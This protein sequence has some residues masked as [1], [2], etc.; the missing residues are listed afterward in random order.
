[1]GNAQCSS[2]SLPGKLAGWLGQPGRLLGMVVLAGLLALSFSM[3]SSEPVAAS[4]GLDMQCRVSG[5]FSGYYNTTNALDDAMEG[6][7]FEDQGREGFGHENFYVLDPADASFLREDAVVVRDSDGWKYSTYR[8]GDDGDIAGLGSFYTS[9]PE[10]VDLVYF[11]EF[12][13]RAGDFARADDIRDHRELR[14]SW[15][16]QGR[17]QGDI[18][19][20][21]RAAFAAAAMPAEERLNVDGDFGVGWDNYSAYWAQRSVAGDPSDIDGSQPVQVFSAGWGDPT[22]SDGVKTDYA[23]IV[24]DQVA[25]LRENVESSKHTAGE[26]QEVS[27]TLSEFPVTVHTSTTRVNCPAG[28]SGCTS[29]HETVASPTVVNAQGVTRE[30]NDGERT[31]SSIEPVGE[32]YQVID[33]GGMPHEVP[34]RLGS[35]AEYSN[36][37]QVRR[38]GGAY[39]VRQKENTSG[40]VLNVIVSLDPEYRRDFTFDFGAEEYG[41]D[42][43]RVVRAFGESSRVW[44]FDSYFESHGFRPSREDWQHGVPIHPSASGVTGWNAL[45]RGEDQF[46]LEN[47]MGYRQPH[48]TRPLAEGDTYDAGVHVFRSKGELGQSLVDDTDD[49]AAYGIRWPVNLEDMSW[50]LYQL[51]GE[52]D[53]SDVSVALWRMWLDPTVQDQ[54][55]RSFYAEANSGFSKSPLFAI[56]SVTDPDTFCDPNLDLDAAGSSGVVCNPLGLRDPDNHEY[57]AILPFENFDDRDDPTDVLRVTDLGP[58]TSPPPPPPMRSR[59]VR[60]GVVSPDDAGGGGMRSLSEFQFSVVES[61]HFNVDSLGAA[62]IERRLG[63]PR[64]EVYRRQFIEALPQESL[65]PNV[66][67]LLVLAFY[68]SRPPQKRGENQTFSVKNPTGGEFD[69]GSTVRLPERHLRR[70][71]CRGVIPPYGWSPPAPAVSGEGV[72]LA[73]RLVNLGKGVYNTAVK[74]QEK[75]GDFFQFFD[76]AATVVN[77]LANL[78][79]DVVGEQARI[80]CSGLAYVDGLQTP[81][82]EGGSSPVLDGRSG[83]SLDVNVGALGREMVERTCEKIDWRS[84]N[85]EAPPC[86]AGSVGAFADNRCEKLLPNYSLKLKRAELVDPRINWDVTAPVSDSYRN[87]SFNA[88]T[89]GRFI[90]NERLDI[91]AGFDRNSGG[92][93]VKS[94]DWSRSRDDPPEFWEFGERDR[95]E[96]GVAVESR[97]FLAMPRDRVQEWALT[98]EGLLG[99]GVNAGQVRVWLE[100]E[101]EFGGFIG[102]NSE[103][104]VDGFV[105][106]VKPD[107]KSHSYMDEDQ[108]LEFWIPRRMEVQV[109]GGHSSDMVFRGFAFGDVG[110]HVGYCA[111]SICQVGDV[112]NWRSDRLSDGGDDLLYRSPHRVSMNGDIS[113][114]GGL[115]NNLP[116]LPGYEHSFQVAA[117]SG[118]RNGHYYQQGAFSAPFVIDGDQGHCLVMEHGVSDGFAGTSGLFSG[119]TEREQLGLEQ[120]LRT[121]TGDACSLNVAHAGFTRAHASAEESALT[122]LLLNVVGNDFCGDI[123]DSTPDT[124]TWNSEVVVYVWRLAWVIAGAIMFVLLVWH[125]VRMTMETWVSSDPVTALRT[126]LPRFVIA[127]SLALGSLWLAELTIVLAGDL[128]CWVGNMTGMS[129]WSAS[130]G[131]I[132]D[133]YRGMDGVMEAM[134]VQV[135]D[136]VSK[137]LLWLSW[138]IIKTVLFVLLFYWI[139]VILMVCVLYFLL[140]IVWVLILRVIMLAVLIALAPI[141]FALYASEVTAHWTRRWVS[142]FLGTVFFQVVL[143]VVLFIGVDMLRQIPPITESAMVNLLISVFMTIAIYALALKVPNIINPFFDLGTSFGEIFT[144][145][146]IGAAAGV[147]VATAGFGAVAGG[148]AAAGS[149]GLGRAG[150]GGVGPAGGGGAGPAGGGGSLTSVG[151]RPGGGLGSGGAVTPGGQQRNVG[152]GSFHPVGWQSGGG[153]VG[154]RASA[155][156]G[157]A[158]GGSAG[159]PLPEARASGGPGSVGSP[160]AVVSGGSPPTRGS[161]VVMS[162]GSAPTRGSSV[163]MSQG[164]GGS[165][166]GAILRGMGGGAVAGFNTG[167]RFNAGVATVASGR[168]LRMPPDE[169]RRGGLEAAPR[170]AVRGLNSATFRGIAA[171][172]SAQRMGQV[173]MSR[174][175]PGQSSTSVGSTGPQV[176]PVT[177]PSVG[178]VPAGGGTSGMVYPTPRSPSGLVSPSGGAAP[179][180]SGPVSTPGGV[181]PPPSGW[182]TGTSGLVYPTSRPAAGPASP[183]GGPAQPAGGA[184]SGAVPPAP[185]AGGQLS[186]GARLGQGLRA[187]VGAVPGFRPVVASGQGLYRATR[188]TQSRLLGVGTFREAFNSVSARRASLRQRPAPPVPPDNSP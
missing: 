187:G 55:A 12:N 148:I 63:L 122:G 147:V 109:N 43:N 23:S 5:V 6:Y 118:D 169:D 153:G 93:K 155:G 188:T 166:F 68:E 156:G 104:D 42:T 150:G 180:P 115:L 54:V 112:Y 137:G 123:L 36:L 35:V 142:M 163:A 88:A 96:G 60:Q 175:T 174:L 130:G 39:E 83:D 186:L 81:G 14:L 22:V 185:E 57:A 1:M 157:V 56:E 80:T 58:L 95:I 89:R 103:R 139:Y 181:A 47:H 33:D 141:A 21:W 27:A 121:L 79:P 145:L 136:A 38:E 134:G 126:L 98:P 167:R 51:P 91:N 106:R 37:S 20:D 164:R 128:S 97:R 165:R 178:T 11:T 182:T 2:R 76:V 41:Q 149:S 117:F 158:S 101:P 151:V 19:V 159:A 31:E 168:H 146:K 176:A 105:I 15:L 125:S 74:L 84:S 92:Y 9:F 67:H 77:G 143:L 26:G 161:S 170:P 59:L 114:F 49:F 138:E 62:D 179:S 3:V 100:L 53:G 119:L 99:S 173:G 85:V 69:E 87:G 102:P 90:S 13:P 78:F 133:L 144:P 162:G 113:G 152:T 72:S 25:G 110:F 129:L 111:G 48:L 177:P 65:N 107:E 94:F 124:L 135:T 46:G 7:G 120:D 40:D 108:F 10:W 132:L 131:V 34:V 16:Y 73:Q 18:V 82:G 52:A 71:V 30:Q 66:S 29:V 64:G 154:A 28:G 183:S 116:L 8:E 75:L 61:S 4:Q 50:Y 24:Q 17:D 127:L 70:V 86:E 184:T 172:A 160:G 45:H 171:S 44:T 140:K 32:T